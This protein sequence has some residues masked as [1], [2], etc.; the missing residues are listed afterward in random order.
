MLRQRILSALVL[1]PCAVLAV[2]F[3][4]WAFIAL[5]AVAGALMAWEWS[6]LCL[7][8]FG[9]DGLFL[10]MMSVLVV[11]LGAEAPVAG[12]TLA[13][14]SAVT[15]P[16]IGRWDGRSP[17]WMAAGALYIGLPALSLVWLRGQGRETVFWL[18]LLVWATDIGAYAAGRAIGGPKLM[19]RVSPKKTW[20]GL[21][22][23]MVSAALVGGGAGLVYEISPTVLALLSAL[24]AIVAQA[25]DLAESWVKRRFGV[26]DSSAIIPG[27]GG[28][29]DRLDGLLA[30]APVVAVICLAMGGGLAQWR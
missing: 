13:V 21:A 26:K 17:L 20:A 18:L 5:A 15:V 12:L 25:G 16:W 23:G 19:P 7:G 11:V 14:G 1:A 30:A 27:H 28:V 4:S 24:L 6:R 3:G 8:R 9:A 10:S 22:G 29:L 2:W